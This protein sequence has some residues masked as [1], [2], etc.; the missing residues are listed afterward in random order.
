MI[1]KNIFGNFQVFLVHNAFSIPVVSFV[2]S[3]SFMCDQHDLMLYFR[4]LMGDILE[5]SKVEE[6]K[7]TH[8][9]KDNRCTF[10]SLLSQ[11]F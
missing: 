2:F 11:K 8:I 5:Q 9:V 3:L 10:F 1:E 7:Q 6:Q 4:A